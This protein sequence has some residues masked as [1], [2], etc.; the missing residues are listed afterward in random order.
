MHAVGCNAAMT[1]LVIARLKDPTSDLKMTPDEESWYGMFTYYFYLR[2][3]TK[4]KLF[5]IVASHFRTCLSLSTI[6]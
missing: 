5:L 4:N 1:G 6:F 3:A 2:N